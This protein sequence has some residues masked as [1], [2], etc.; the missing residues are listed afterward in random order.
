MN[1]I[2]IMISHFRIY[3]YI[4]KEQCYNSCKVWKVVINFNQIHFQHLAYYFKNVCTQFST[5]NWTYHQM[6]FWKT[7][8]TATNLFLR[9][10]H[11]GNCPLPPLLLLPCAAVDALD[12]LDAVDALDA[13]DAVDAVQLTWCSVLLWSMLPTL[14]NGLLSVSCEVDHRPPPP[15]SDRNSWTGRRAWPMAPLT[16]RCSN[17]RPDK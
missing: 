7:C 12:A 1:S 17:L 11:R 8:S 6:L 10:H 14:S 13:L 2:Y 5:N 3:I 16:L 4:S 9:R 15:M